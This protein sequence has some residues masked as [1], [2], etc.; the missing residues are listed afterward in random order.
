MFSIS[1]AANQFAKARRAIGLPPY[2]ELNIPMD[3]IETIVKS[4]G[5]E[6]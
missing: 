5:A 2:H 1:C 6:P 3:A 4:T